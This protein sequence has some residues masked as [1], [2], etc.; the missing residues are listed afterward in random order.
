MSFKVPLS[1]IADLM[2]LKD[3]IHKIE[4]MLM[5]NTLVVIVTCF[6]KETCKRLY[7][8]GVSALPKGESE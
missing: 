5:D 1:L 2:E 7:D 4:L 3:K 8:I 6:D